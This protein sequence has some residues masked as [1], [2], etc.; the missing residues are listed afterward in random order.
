MRFAVVAVAAAGLALAGC[1]T[2]FGP[3]EQTIAVSTTPTEGADCILSSKD[4]TWHVITPGKAK[5][6]SDEDLQIHCSKQGWIDAG[7]TIPSDFDIW[8]LDDAYP[9]T[10]DVPMTP[11][12]RR[13]E[14][15]PDY[16]P[17]SAPAAPYNPGL[18]P[19]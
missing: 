7:G 3:S 4:G 18:S 17:S 12:P 11:V 16:G 9:D 2:I 14:Q 1:S 10:F 8:S 13:Q 5:V 6:T 15:T 19:G